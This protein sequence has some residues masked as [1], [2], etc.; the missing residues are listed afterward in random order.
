MATIYSMLLFFVPDVLLEMQAL[1]AMQFLV[2]FVAHQIGLKVP[3]MGIIYGYRH[4]Y[5]VISVMSVMLTVR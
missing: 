1:V 2:E 4:Q 5:P 3:S